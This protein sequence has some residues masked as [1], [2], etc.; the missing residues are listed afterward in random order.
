MRQLF[1]LL[2]I[3]ESSQLF[4]QTDTTFF[5]SET[6][7]AQNLKYAKYFTLDKIDTSGQL[8]LLD[9]KNTH[10]FITYFYKKMPSNNYFTQNGEATY[11]YENGKIQKKGAFK[12]GIK[13]DIW[14]E[15]YESGNPKES[16]KYQ[17][18]DFGYDEKHLLDYDVLEHWDNLG[19]KAVENGN[20]L[21]FFRDSLTV[22]TVEVKN[23]VPNGVCKGTY[24]GYSFSEIH[25]KG[26]LK[27]GQI[28]VDGKLIDYDKISEIAIF[29][30]GIREMYRF[31]AQNL[32]YPKSA[33][34]AN[35]SGRVFVKFAVEKDGTLSE[36]SVLK[37]IGF[38]CDEETLRVVTLMNGNWV[39]AKKRGLSERIYFTMPVSF[40]LE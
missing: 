26:E 12:E 19:V 11:F 23:G 32:K 15:F 7:I 9:L 33:Q 10:K 5:S 29:K 36:F 6:V 8:T 21:Y 3:F 37:G 28:S 4:A 38:G 24:R 2:F 22:Y 31:I 39:G 16:I 40:V 20:G 30:G 17:V 34:K 13:A 35:I 27:S 18:R 1:L 14:Q 25:K